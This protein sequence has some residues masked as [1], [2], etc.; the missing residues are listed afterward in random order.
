MYPLNL[1]LL[2]LSVHQDA[3]NTDNMEEVNRILDKMGFTTE[4]TGH[5][6]EEF[7]DSED[8]SIIDDISEDNN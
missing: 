2:Q 6:K 1:R 7:F 5:R 4:D 8:N 3:F